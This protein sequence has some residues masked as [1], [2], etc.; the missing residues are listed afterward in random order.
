MPGKAFCLRCV[1]VN[2]KLIRLTFKTNKRTIAGFG[3]WLDDA[4]SW[5]RD[6]RDRLKSR[7]TVDQQSSINRARFERAFS[8]LTLR[9]LAD[10]KLHGMRALGRSDNYVTRCD[11]L[12]SQCVPTALQRRQLRGVRAEELARCLKRLDATPGKARVLRAFIGQILTGAGEFQRGA[13]QLL[14]QTQKIYSPEYEPRRLYEIPRV[15]LRKL[16]SLFEYLAEERGN[17]LQALYLRL[18]FE[19]EV[20]FEVL[21]RAR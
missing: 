15:S 9:Q 21:L 11:K 1:D 10:A 2:G 5:A 8:K 4:R 13:W 16:R 14:R 7:L 19:F 20:P 18:L 12:F 6:E 17:V 3:S